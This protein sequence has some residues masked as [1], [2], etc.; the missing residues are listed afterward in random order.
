MSNNDFVD[1]AMSDRDNR[2]LTLNRDHEITPTYIVRNS[3]VQNDPESLISPR[4]LIRALTTYWYLTIPVS[5]LLAVLSATA[6]LMTFTPVYRANAV[7]KIASYAPYIAYN[8]PEPQVNS[9]EF[10]ET[11]IELIRSSLVAEQ[12]LSDETIGKLPTVQS[13]ENPVS[14]LTNNI[15]VQQVGSSELYNIYLETPDP[16]DSS[17]LVNAV[18]D[19]YFAVRA[20]D[21]QD[22]TARVLELLGQEKVARGEEIQTLREKM[23]QLGQDVVGMDPYTGMPE[24]NNGQAGAGPLERLRE[25][26]TAAEVDRKMLEME[27]TAIREAIAKEDLRIA[28]VDVEMAVGESQEILDL[29]ARIAERKSMMHRVEST[30]AGGRSDPSYLRL[31]AEIEGYEASLK[32]AVASSRPKITDQLKSLAL[33]DRRDTL[34]ELEARLETQLVLENLLGLRYKE[35]LATAGESGNKMLELEFARAELAREERV[36]EMIAERSMALT[37]E[38]RA[39]GRVALLQP[40][41]P[42]LRPIATFP[43]MKM[44]IAALLSGCVPFGL[45]LLWEL[46]VKPISDV[47]QLTNDGLLMSVNEVAKL[48]MR[49]FAIGSKQSKAMNIFEESIDSLRIGIA[50]PEKYSGVRVLAVTSAVHGEG[51]SSISSQLAVSIGRATGEPVLLVDGDLRAPDVHNI[52]QVSNGLGMAAVLAGRASL[53]EAIIR[54]WSEHLHLLPA[55]RLRTNPH[56][57]M[58]R[59]LLNKIFTELRKTYRYIVIDTPPIL[60]ASEALLLAKCADGAII[61]TRRNVSREGQVKIAYERLAKAGVQPLSAVLNGVPTRCYARTYGSYEYARKFE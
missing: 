14:W 17:I 57:L 49:T 61:C 44:V 10:T 50:L 37:T 38:S 30:A 43:L 12:V 4:Y 56:Q 26:L 58:T 36:F 46:S 25:R 34:H 54:D 15:R 59:D 3:S 45:A 8:T 32:R 23:R 39:P 2:S 7:M 47:Q 22:Q 19:A 33:L 1:A 11:Q 29:R 16:E 48:P 24:K 13:L 21:N 35:M 40:A 18:L 5:V 60:S 31:Q 27:I 52:F 6:M 55:G 9:E 20:K 41:E 42:S 51:K 53:D 28:E